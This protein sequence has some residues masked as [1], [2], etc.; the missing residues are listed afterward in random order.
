MRAEAV[1]DKWQAKPVNNRIVLGLSDFFCG[2]LPRRALYGLADASQDW[3][4][5][6]HP[7]LLG[8]LER[9][10][11]G[12]FPS[13]TPEEIEATARRIPLTYVRGVVDYMR[14]RKAP[15]RIISDEGPGVHFITG[16]GAKIVVTAH[17]GNWEVG[18]FY[19]GGAIGPHWI[20]A[21]PERDPGVDRLRDS[22]REAFGLSSLHGGRGVAGLMELRAIL[23]R[24]ESVI[25][26]A[27]RAI[28]KDCQEVSFM[29]RKAYFLRS[30]GLLAQLTGVPVVPVAVVAEGPGVYR[31]MAGDPVMSSGD[32]CTPLQ[33]AADFFSQV[34]ARYPDQWYNF[35]PYWEEP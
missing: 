12:A 3:Y 14:A 18:G 5:R 27:D 1:Y 4:C 25:I 34:L 35:F 22:K 32:P 29:G 7:E 13:W 8:T 10:L 21:F 28:G 15:P 31:G 33:A 9:N 11:G 6:H 16:S 19:L 26:L 23:N 2:F 24:G 20:L 17:M 30:P